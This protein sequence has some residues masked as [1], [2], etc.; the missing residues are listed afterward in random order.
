MIEQVDVLAAFI[1][2]QNVQPKEVAEENSLLRFSPLRARLTVMYA[3]QVWAGCEQF[4]HMTEYQSH[5]TALAKWLSKLANAL[6][7]KLFMN[8]ERLSEKYRQPG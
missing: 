2:T 6:K 3:R 4:A 1:G 7:G 5:L 8:C